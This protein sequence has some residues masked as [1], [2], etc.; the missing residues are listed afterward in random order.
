MKT[1]NNILKTILLAIVFTIAYSSCNKTSIEEVHFP[2]RVELLVGQYCLPQVVL[3]EY[4]Y[5]NGSMI[6]GGT[7]TI[8]GVS[9]TSPTYYNR[10]LTTYTFSDWMSENQQIVAEK[11]D[12]LLALTTGE[13]DVKANYRDNLGEH[14]ATCSV[15]V[16]DLDVPSPEDTIF[17]HAGETIEL[18]KFDVSG[19]YTI[20]Y[21]LHYGNGYVYTSRLDYY[22]NSQTITTGPSPL[23][24]SP[25]YTYYKNMIV[26][27]SDITSF[28]IFCDPLGID[29]TISM[30]MLP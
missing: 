20:N 2:K 12:T 27:E 26:P 17:V 7:S 23:K 28:R 24:L 6:T 8:N 18:C 4:E 10:K 13:C 30:V 15:V 16:K 11:G 1:M 14:T 21:E 22:S 19:V 5:S 25:L 9:Y 3:D 29:V